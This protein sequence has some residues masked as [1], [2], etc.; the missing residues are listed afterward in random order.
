M[1]VECP[2]LLFPFMRQIMA[3]ATRNGNY[4]PLML[5]PIDFMGIYLANKQRNQQQAGGEA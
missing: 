4:P 5:E 2:R 1:L 3:D